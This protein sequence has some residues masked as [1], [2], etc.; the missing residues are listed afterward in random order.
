MK[1]GVIKLIHK[2]YDLCEEAY[3]SVTF[4]MSEMPMLSFFRRNA[5]TSVQ[6]PVEKGNYEVVHRVALPKEIPQGQSSSPYTQPFSDTVLSA[7][8]N[9]EVRAYTIDEDDLFCVNLKVDFMKKP[10][11]KLPLGW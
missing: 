10:F 2:E 3:V 6:C 4:A 9:I 8:F 7:K 5:N 11:F 1:L